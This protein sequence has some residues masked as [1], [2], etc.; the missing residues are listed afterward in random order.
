MTGP[1]VAAAARASAADNFAA[2]TKR[3]PLA[4]NAGARTT[5]AQDPDGA[6]IPEDR[7]SDT[8]AVLAPLVTPPVDP[9]TLLHPATYLCA[10]CAGRFPARSRQTPYCSPQC[11]AEAKA[12][13]YAR[14][15]R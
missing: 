3:A 1:R 2:A 15:Q 6:V 8:P 13:R 14:T 12:V 9:P 11:T 7:A 5:G 4:K 10:N